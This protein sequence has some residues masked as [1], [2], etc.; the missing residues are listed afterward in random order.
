MWNARKNKNEFKK[1]IWFKIAFNSTLFNRPFPQK[2]LNPKKRS[3]GQIQGV[4][5]TIRLVYIFIKI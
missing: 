4:I 3:S 1:K 2:M 5:K